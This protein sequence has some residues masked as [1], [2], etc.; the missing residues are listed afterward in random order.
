[1]RRETLLWATMFS[2]PTGVAA[3]SGVYFLA[4]APVM[5]ASFGVALAAAI[6]VLVA[7]GARPSG[8]TSDDPGVGESGRR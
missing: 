3:A 6:F 1:M 4:N 7:V 2:I 8:S 5:A